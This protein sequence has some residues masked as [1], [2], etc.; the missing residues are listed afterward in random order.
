MTGEQAQAFALA[1]L[2]EHGLKGWVFGF[3]VSRRRLGL[4]DYNRKRVSISHHLLG[5]SDFEVRE[6]IL[7]EISHALLWTE[8]GVDHGHDEVWKARA[9]SIGSLGTRLGRDMRV[10]RMWRATCGRCGTVHKSLTLRRNRACLCDPS[11]ATVALVYEYD[12]PPP[13]GR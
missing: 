12:A 3:D 13:E 8:T 10:K 9:R 6:T 4:C 1:K 2:A 7:H 5:K 11:V